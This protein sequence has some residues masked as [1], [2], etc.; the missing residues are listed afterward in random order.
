[1]ISINEKHGSPDIINNFIIEN[2]I[3]IF[4]SI[5]SNLSE[6][7]F[8]INKSILVN[9]RIVNFD[10]EKLTI[11]FKY[12]KPNYYANL[13]HKQCIES[14]FN[15]CIIESHI[16]I[17]FDEKYVL[18]SLSHEL[19]HLYELYQIKNIYNK[20]VW[21]RTDALNYYNDK[22]ILYFRDI[23]YLSLPQEVRATVSSIRIFLHGIDKN[24]LLQNLKSTNEWK[25]SQNLK[26][27]KYKEYL[28]DLKLTHNIDDII[29]SFLY[30]NKIMN[31]KY[32]IRYESDL[33][34]YLNKMC[35]YF[36]HVGENI[37]KKLLNLVS[38]ITLYEDKGIHIDTFEDFSYENYLNNKTYNRE[39]N[40][41]TLLE[42]IEYIDFF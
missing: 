41:E 8:K 21:K 36:H 39:R 18:K 13:S 20:T 38:D 6:I 22:S 34:E 32:Q 10:I 2:K 7:S 25:N 40:L 15:N 27:F 26:N 12:N 16:P 14:E 31:I 30:F 29:F 35:V 23:F 17:K 4:K 42:Y 1:M 19:T 11:L 24:L 3:K 9:K 37:E 28:D 5:E 33:L